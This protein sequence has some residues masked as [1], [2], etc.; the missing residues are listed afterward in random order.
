LPATSDYLREQ[1][2]G[3]AFIAFLATWTNFVEDYSVP[4]DAVL[5]DIDEYLKTGHTRHSQ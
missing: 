3:E 1:G 2:L 4:E 5:F